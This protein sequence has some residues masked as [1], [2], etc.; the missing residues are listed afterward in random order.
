MR[1]TQNKKGGNR[2][3]IQTKKSKKRTYLFDDLEGKSKQ[4]IIEMRSDTKDALQTANVQRVELQKERNQLVE[5]VQEM[6]KTFKGRTKERGELLDRLKK[7]QSERDQAQKNRD[8][9]DEKVPP[10][11]EDIE[12]SL[13]QRHKPLSTM[14]NDL[15]E[16]PTLK[17]EIALFE[18]F[19][20][21]QEMHKIAIFANDEHKKMMAAMNEIKSVMQD[22]KKLDKKTEEENAKLELKSDEEKNE[23]NKV[24]WKEI[25]RISSRINEIDEKRKKIKQEIGT[26]TNELHRIEAFQRMQSD[27][28]R[29]IEL[30]PEEI[31]DKAASGGTLSLQDLSTL[32]ASGGLENLNDS[33]K[34][35]GSGFTKTDRK[36]KTRRRSNARRGKAR[37]STLTPKEERKD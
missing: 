2:R 29:R 8:D 3:K 27:A 7:A 19:F 18:S 6:R 10:S 34:N 36:K 14:M 15:R 4:E 1:R 13:K 31:R 33:E 23:S 24:G 25:E 17:R 16:M 22:F 5:I 37:T 35:D 32:I 9:A 20:E 30:N 21:Y 12:R 28:A 26:L 11:P